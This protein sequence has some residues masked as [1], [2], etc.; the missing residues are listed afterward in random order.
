MQCRKTENSA[1]RLSCGNF[2][3][4]VNNDIMA[5]CKSNSSSTL[6]KLQILSLSYSTE[7]QEVKQMSLPHIVRW[8]SIDLLFTHSGPKMKQLVLCKIIILIPKFGSEPTSPSH[9][10]RKWIYLCWKIN[11][12]LSP[13]FTCTSPL[14]FVLYN[15]S[16]LVLGTAVTS[17]NKL[18]R[19]LNY[20]STMAE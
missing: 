14:C 12:Q 15:L 2:I 5:F 3:D 13:E 16:Q 20:L 17:R 1:T 9:E 7:T 11:N 8:S 19:L 6:Q 4:Q 10:S 18:P